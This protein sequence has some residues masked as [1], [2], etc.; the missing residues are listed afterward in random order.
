VLGQGQAFISPLRAGCRQSP[1]GRGCQQAYRSLARYPG[2]R[3]Y[4]A[5]CR[6]QVA[7]AGSGP[8][9]SSALRMW[10]SPDGVGRPIGRA[11]EATGE[12]KKVVRPRR[13]G[14]SRGCRGRWEKL[15]RS[16]R[17][18]QVYRAQGSMA[19]PIERRVITEKEMTWG[20]RRLVR[21]LLGSLENRTPVTPGNDVHN[22]PGRI[23]EEVMGRAGRRLATGEWP[24]TPWE[25]GVHAGLGCSRCRC[26]RGGHSIDLKRKCTRTW[27]CLRDCF[28]R[29]A[30]EGRTCSR[31]GMWRRW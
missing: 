12:E 10:C 4:R 31:V 19:Y 9:F 3:A 30:G 1:S 17:R 24:Q 26:F 5:A 29:L 13:D 27:W 6:V 18:G 23:Q 7:T 11:G 20:A 2:P 8:C 15:R 21:G 16:W 22:A 14:L 25:I 28:I